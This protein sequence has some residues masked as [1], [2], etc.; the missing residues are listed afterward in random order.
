MRGGKLLGLPSGV[1]TN[2]CDCVTYELLSSRPCLPAR[3]ALVEGRSDLPVKTDMTCTAR[4]S[5][6]LVE[7]HASDAG[8]A[9]DSLVNGRHRE[10]VV[11]SRRGPEPKNR[12]HA[13]RR[14]DLDVA[15]RRAPHTVTSRAR[16]CPRFGQFAAGPAE[17]FPSDRPANS[18]RGGPNLSVM[19]SRSGRELGLTGYT[20]EYVR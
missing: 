12:F 19:R 10:L 2:C 4:S 13:P 5:S 15:E 17:S 8:S 20:D 11:C 14:L 3:V 7:V 18:H 16:Q 6:N 9:A 1:Q